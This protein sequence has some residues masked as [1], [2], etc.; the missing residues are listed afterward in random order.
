MIPDFSAATW[1]VIAIA[2]ALWIGGGWAFFADF[3]RRLK[4]RKD[5][6]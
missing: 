3:G 1:V 2:A 4:G 6:R 5:D